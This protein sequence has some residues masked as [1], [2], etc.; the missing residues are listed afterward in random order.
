MQSRSLIMNWG[1]DCTF[2]RRSRSDPRRSVLMLLTVG[3]SS[4]SGSGHTAESDWVMYL[5]SDSLGGHS[6]RKYSDGGRNGRFNLEVGVRDSGWS[7]ASRRGEDELDSL[8][9]HIRIDYVDRK[10]PGRRNVGERHKCQSI[11]IILTI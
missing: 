2:G 11:C 8:A 1:S 7:Q 5:G 10:S 3:G 4:E 6:D 9:R